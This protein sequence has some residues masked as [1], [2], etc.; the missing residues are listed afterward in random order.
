MIVNLQSIQV[1]QLEAFKREIA[2]FPAETREDIFSLVH[3]FLKG[4]RLNNRDF[5]TFKI[6]KCTKIQEFKVRDHRGNWRAV[7]TMIQGKYLVFVYAFHKKSQELQ[8]DK[9]VIRNRIKRISI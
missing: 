7:S 5:K 6:D 1:F 4:E 8:E 9:D 3:R 2:E